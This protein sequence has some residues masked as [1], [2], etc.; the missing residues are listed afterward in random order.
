VFEPQLRYRSDCLSGYAQINFCAPNMKHPCLLPK[1]ITKTTLVGFE[2]AIEITFIFKINFGRE[3]DMTYPI[4]YISYVTY[5]CV[6]TQLIK[7]TS[8]TLFES[9]SAIHHQVRTI[10]YLQPAHN[11]EI[12]CWMKLLTA[13]L[14]YLKNALNFLQTFRKP[15]RKHTIKKKKNG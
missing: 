3:K 5:L 7:V 1:T 8:I 4:C 10:C 11:S 13:L 9:L 12:C 2:H 15:E 6:S 14:L